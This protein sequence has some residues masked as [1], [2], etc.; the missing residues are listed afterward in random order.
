MIISVFCYGGKD[1]KFETNVGSV[2]CRFWVLICCNNFLSLKATVV[3]LFSPPSPA[4]QQQLV[5]QTTPQQPSVV[6]TVPQQPSV[7]QAV[8]QQ[9]S[10]VQAVPQ[11]P[12]VQTTPQ[13]PSVVQRTPQQQSRATPVRRRLSV[14]S[15]QLASIISPVRRTV[16]RSL[17]GSLADNQ[18]EV[19]GL[20]TQISEQQ[21]Q[22]IEYHKLTLERL[23]TLIAVLSSPSEP[24]APPVQPFISP[25]PPVQP[26]IS[27]APPVQPFISPAP[28]VQPLDTPTEPS[29]QPPPVQPLNTTPTE[30]LVQPFATPAAQADDEDSVIFKLRSRS[31]SSKNFAVQ[32]VRFFFMPHELEGRNVRGVMN[33]LPLD[34]DKISKVKDTVF[35]FFPVAASQQDVLWRDCRKAID[36][37]LRNRKSVDVVRSN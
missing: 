14:G 24:T 10:V 20:L 31:T 37:F 11:Q 22:C 21:K 6:Q 35:K 17:F 12:L 29:T 25:A 3:A 15:P 1:I 7:V 9:P 33:K 34:A 36:A 30:L 23:D 18:P 4:P 8:P 28:P 32:L 5:L 19:L 2:K 26:F 13:H 27:P 16:P